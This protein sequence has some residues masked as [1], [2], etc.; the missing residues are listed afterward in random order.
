M[1]RLLL[2]YGSHYY[3]NGDFQGS[4]DSEADATMALAGVE[5]DWYQIVDSFK[6]KIIL[7]K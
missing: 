7:S 1:K 3:P 6:A 5:C 2:F 4:F